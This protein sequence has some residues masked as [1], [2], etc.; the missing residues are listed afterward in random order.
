MM[1]T[2]ISVTAIALLFLMACGSDSKKETT[3]SSETDKKAMA[4]KFIIKASNSMY[5]SISSDSLLIANQP[6]PTKAEVFEKVDLGNG[7]MGIKTSGGKFLSDNQANESKVDAIRTKA[8]TW[9]EFEIIALDQLTAVI[10]T[11][12]GK[13]IC[14][15]QSRDNVLF[16][17]RDKAGAW[18]T[19]IF[20]AK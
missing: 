11:S 7:W 18:E 12:G 6:D 9:E 8:S 1:K 4:D 2:K 19:F 16:A 14:A 17:N 15:D 20:E 10:R 5:L 13:Y 3:A